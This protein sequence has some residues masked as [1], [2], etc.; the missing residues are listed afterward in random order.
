VQFS[1]ER[2][3]EVAAAFFRSTVRSAGLFYRWLNT[4]T[5]HISNFYRFL[6]VIQFVCFDPPFSCF[7]KR[8]WIIIFIGKKA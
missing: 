1:E 4:R 6:K 5:D 7:H 2:T 8:L 3:Q